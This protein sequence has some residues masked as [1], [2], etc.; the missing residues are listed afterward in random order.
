MYLSKVVIKNFRSIKHAEID[1][2]PGKNII[3]GRN[4]S[5][6]SNIV[7]AINLVLGENSPTWDKS[8]NIIDSDFYNQ[9]TNENILIECHLKRHSQENS[10]EPEE[11]SNF[12]VVADE[13]IK[14]QKIEV[15]RNDI[16]SLFRYCEKE[17]LNK[18]W[19]GNKTYSQKTAS[20][21][22]KEANT[23]ILCF[24]ATYIKETFQS[25]KSLILLYGNEKTNIFHLCPSASSLRNA[26]IQSA[27][28]PSFRDPKDQLRLSN[29]TWYGKLIKKLLED[30][31]HKDE[32]ETAFEAVS[33]VS[34]KIF[35]EVDESINE[36]KIKFAFPETNVSIRFN[37][38]SS[39]SDLY[40]NALI[41]I[42]D[43]FLST[44]HSKGAGVQSAIIIGL[45]HYYMKKIARPDEHALL[46]VEEPELYLHP[47]ARRVISDRLTEFCNS[48][49]KR[50]NQVIA[51]TH[52]SEFVCC[53]HED[54][55]LIHV[56]KCS[57][58]GSQ[59]Q[60]TEFK[61]IKEKQ[62]LIK[63]QN[64]EMFFADLV[65]LVEGADKYILEAIAE[66][67]GKDKLGSS[68]WLNEYNISIISCGGK[69][70][71]AKYVSK[72]KDLEIK[73]F[74]LADFDYLVEGINELLTIIDTNL[75][76]KKNSCFSNVS[77]KLSNKNEDEVNLDTLNQ[78]I[79]E[80][81]KSFPKTDTQKLIGEIKR[82][83]NKYS[84]QKLKRL[85]QITDQQ[86][87]DQIK[88]L[89]NELKKQNIFI[90]SGEL[91]DFYLEKSAQLQG[92]K[93][94]KPLQIIRVKNENNKSIK[95]YIQAD[96]FEL[97]LDLIQKQM[98]MPTKSKP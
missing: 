59:V 38:K 61:N 39:P 2:K 26:F 90:L 35:K 81:F 53:P 42:D 67:F 12:F 87:K 23:F 92:S 74:V 57:L 28:I 63:K 19:I 79:E 25:S 71:F 4:N 93:E 6:K 32:L 94:Q 29:W 69:A 15:D 44:L 48:E 55:N 98:S 76:D 72:L 37:S 49:E 52:S 24:Q 80:T 40:K 14:K 7:Q 73:Y 13:Y 50:Q 85:E 97:L 17:N 41:Y 27:I 3:V 56:R 66:E 11:N 47:H 18:I 95:D 64:A 34:Q 45:F 1:F 91:E 70:E 54:L 16:E 96:E 46:I 33:E 10:W 88:D 51:T 58:D 43:G 21:E 89:I 62:I 68:N 5:G 9:N 60:T 84:V 82:T 86:K 75:I 77:R 8:D 36:S 31:N 20:D 22:L 30:H 78:S 65:V 83:V